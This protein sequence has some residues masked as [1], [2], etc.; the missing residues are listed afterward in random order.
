MSCENQD[1]ESE[2]RR[3]CA[4]AAE[5]G[6]PVPGTDS[7]LTAFVGTVVWGEESRMKAEV[8]A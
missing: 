8:I 3:G 5:V 1:P 6:L 7:S 4:R 2:G